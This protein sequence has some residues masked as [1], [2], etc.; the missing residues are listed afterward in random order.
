MLV[1]NGHFLMNK[2]TFYII[3]IREYCS[4]QEKTSKKNNYGNVN[5]FSFHCK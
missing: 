3:P 1:L 4:K 5:W 2:Q